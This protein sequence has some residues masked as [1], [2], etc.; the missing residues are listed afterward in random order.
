VNVQFDNPHAFWLLLLIPV[1]LYWVRR[2]ATTVAVRYPSIR[3]L[4]LLPKSFR[5]RMRWLLPFLRTAGLV[6]LVVVL[7]R[8]TR[9]IESEQ[10]PSK[11]IGIAMLV[12]RSG[13]MGD[14]QNK[15]MY[16]DELKLRFSVA[17]DVL[18]KFIDGDGDELTGRPNDLIGL[19]TFATYPRMDHPFALDHHSLVSM[20]AHM[21]AEKPYLDEFG[22]P[23]DDPEEAAI[24]TDQYGRRRYKINPLQRT[25]LKSAIEYA[26]GKLVFLDEDLHRP[27][28]GLDAYQLKSKILVLLTD[29]IPTV[30]K[31]DKPDFADEDTVQ[32]LKEEGIKVYYIQILSRKRYRE[33]SDGTIEVVSQVGGL[34]SYMQNTRRQDAINEAIEKGRELARKTGGQH[35]LATTGDQLKKVYERIDKL[36]RSEVGGRAVFTHQECYQPYLLAALALFA[37]ELLLGLTWLRRTP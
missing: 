3:N 28:G 10:L 19:C 16:D 24:V 6:L 2:R 5:Q 20:M 23:T 30:G 31:G 18:R 32:M 7:A 22:R 33:R 21:E 36:E 4:K 9:E 27:T 29:G 17:K 37:A 25:S 1:Y 11:G 8:P 13:S 12:D 15:M 26:A 14:V 34:F 35:F